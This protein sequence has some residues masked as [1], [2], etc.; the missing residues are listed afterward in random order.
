MMLFTKLYRDF[1]RRAHRRK[2]SR[3]SVFY[4]Y[5]LGFIKPALTSFRIIPSFV[6]YFSKSQ[7]IITIFF[8]DKTV[9]VVTKKL[10]P[11]RFDNYFQVLITLD[12][13]HVLSHDN[14]RDIRKAQ[15]EWTLARGQNLYSIIS[16]Q[17]G[18][19]ETFRCSGV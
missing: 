15:E 1:P 2:S 12:C 10:N 14:S 6:F 7:I 5:S 19:N 17:R 13:L 16:L 4:T 8:F 3:L 18:L 9:K 11:S